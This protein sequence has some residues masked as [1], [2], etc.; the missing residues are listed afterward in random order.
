MQETKVQKR[1][2]AYKVRINELLK[3]RYIRGEG[4]WAPNYIEAGDKQVSRANILAVVVSKSEEGNYHSIGID[5]G[6]GKISA[7]S[8]EEESFADGIDIGEIILLIGRPREYG[9]E[10]YIV[11]EIIKKIGNPLWV[12]AR[13]MEL[14]KNKGALVGQ[15]AE[16]AAGYEETEIKTE[17]E[18]VAAK[19]FE[20][21]KGVDSGEGVDIEEIIKKA[22]LDNAENIIENLLKNGEI[23]E[24]KPGRI[25]VLE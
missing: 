17:T 19:I 10:R 2:V 5:D 7:R 11:P 21:I 16:L 4:E 24:V 20:L 6:S 14:K 13:E 22:N 9:S 18:D 15:E 8:F 1:Q 23:F 12:K 25:K 3:G